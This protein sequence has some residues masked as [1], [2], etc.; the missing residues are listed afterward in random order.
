MNIFEWVE[1][2]FSKAFSGARQGPGERDGERPDPRT[3]PPGV[4]AVVGQSTEERM[5][6]ADLTEE[7]KSELLSQARAE[8]ASGNP[9]AELE[10]LIVQRAD[11][12]AA[13]RIAEAARQAHITDLCNRLAGGSTSCPR[14]LP[15]P[16]AELA[17][18]L[19]SLSGDAQTAAEGILS[20]IV[21]AGLVDYK[22]HG[23]SRTQQGNALLAP[24]MSAQLSKWLETPGNTIDEFFKINAVELGA[25]AD[26]NLTDFVGK[27]K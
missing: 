18:F 23:S 24:E 1:M 19:S 3:N 14:G 15:I 12:L 17:V 16:A 26:Y 11:A 22:E 7:Q 2:L 8:L 13:T 20:R 25:R 27:E 6:Y 10:A 9:P 21:E 5:K 4:R